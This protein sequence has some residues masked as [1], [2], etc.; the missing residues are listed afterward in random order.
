MNTMAIWSSAC[1][2][3]VILLLIA[4]WQGSEL[5]QWLTK[6]V[7][8]GCFL[9]LAISVADW[10]QP[11]ARWIMLGLCLGAVGDQLLIRAHQRAWFLSGLVVFLLGHL[12]YVLAFLSVDPEWL[13]RAV[14]SAAVLLVLVWRWI[15]SG[16]PGPMRAPVLT[17]LMVIGLML[18]VA[19]GAQSTVGQ[20]PVLGAFLFATSDVLV[21]RERF[22]KPGSTA[23]VFST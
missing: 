3:A 16:V 23:T 22:V 15:G 9:A 1:G 21:A 14:V 8:S 12:A 2:A 20:L 11:Y 4:R 6:P 5:G 13:F 18:V 19:I 17:Y 7:A 10:Q